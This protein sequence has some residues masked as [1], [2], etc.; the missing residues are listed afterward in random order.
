MMRRPP[1]TT[2]TDT[3]FPYTTLFRSRFGAGDP[4][5]DV[6]G[7]EALDAAGREKVPDGRRGGGSTTNRPQGEDAA[8]KTSPGLR[9]EEPTSELQ[10]LMRLSYAVFCLKKKTHTTLTIFNIVHHSIP[11][12]ILTN[13]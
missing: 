12:T 11:I 1:R 5:P 10:Y 13:T 8:A 6:R 3:L 2:R 4:A 9:S 7:S